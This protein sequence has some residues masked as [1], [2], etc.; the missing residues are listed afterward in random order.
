MS[1]NLMFPVLVSLT[2]SSA[3]LSG[4]F[5]VFSNFA[6]NAFSRI[7]AESGVAAMQSIN[8][9]IL[10]PGFLGIFGGTALG[11][12]GVALAAILNWSHPSSS[13]ALSGG[14]FYLIGCFAVTAMFNVPLNN[15]LETVTAH[16]PGASV[17]WSSYVAGW[18]PWNHVRTLATLLAALA[19]LIAVSKLG[20]G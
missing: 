9:V 17:A 1:A 5:F 13:W 16:D 2:L 8:R 4:L 6:M 18:Q 3:M 11:S 20:E 15:Q 10:N 12:I 19:Y 7:P 14:L